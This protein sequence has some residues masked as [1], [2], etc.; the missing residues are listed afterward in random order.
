MREG[1]GLVVVGDRGVALKLG[2]AEGE[3]SE[4][5]DAEGG[6]AMGVGGWRRGRGLDA[7]DVEFYGF[8]PC[9]EVA[10]LRNGRGKRKRT[11]QEER[12]KVEV[13]GQY[14]RHRH[15]ESQDMAKE[16]MDIGMRE[17]GRGH[18]EA[19]LIHRFAAARQDER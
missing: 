1:G 11:S 8:E 3:E 12:I 15:R 9:I 7:W 5:G 6:R 10:I 18:V 13:D 16:A 19:L 2:I 4:G 17:E 14:H